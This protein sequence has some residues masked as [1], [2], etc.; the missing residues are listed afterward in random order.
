MSKPKK[1]KKTARKTARPVVKRFMPRPEELRNTIQTERTALSEPRALALP[2]LW[3]K[4]ETPARVAFL[5]KMRADVATAPTGG[6]KRP[7]MLARVL[8]RD[9]GGAVKDLALSA[10]LAALFAMI[11]L[12]GYIGRTYRITRHRRHERKNAAGYTVEEETGGA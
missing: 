4:I 10:P 6:R 8:D 1:K 7:E 5:E 3:L 9:D 11:P 2:E 12:D